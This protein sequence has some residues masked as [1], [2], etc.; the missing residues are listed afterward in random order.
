LNYHP[1]PL[2]QCL[3]DSYTWLKAEGLI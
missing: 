1:R 3:R 2:E